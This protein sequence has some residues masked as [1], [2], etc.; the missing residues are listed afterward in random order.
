MAFALARRGLDLLRERRAFHRDR[1]ALRDSF[2]HQHWDEHSEQVLSKMTWPDAPVGVRQGA[3]WAVTMVR[4][5]ADVIERTVRHLI[6]QGVEAI[7]V[8]DN[9]STDE[10][11]RILQ[12][13]AG[14]FPLFVVH[15]AETAYYQ[16]VKMSLLADWARR[17]G[18]GWILSLIHI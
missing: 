3:L 1:L 16:A 7:L 17:N 15:D 5:E 11:P 8:A 2:E 9:G 4:D 10:T 6:G 12:R 18:A 14:E 13:L